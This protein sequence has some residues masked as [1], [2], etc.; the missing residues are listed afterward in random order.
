MVPEVHRYT[1]IRPLVGDPVS[2]SASIQPVSL[3]SAF[4]PVGLVISL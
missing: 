4:Q 2:T 1:R 3:G